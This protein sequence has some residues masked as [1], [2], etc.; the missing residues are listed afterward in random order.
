MQRGGAPCQAARSS[1]YGCRTAHGLPVRNR[2][3]SIYQKAG[4]AWITSLVFRCE[5]QSGA[6]SC[7]GLKML[8]HDL[9]ELP[10]NRPVRLRNEACAYC[11]VA[12]SKA[13]RTKDHVIG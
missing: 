5:F 6:D 9:T 2:L 11:G 8:T 10:A 4:H 1:V 13:N 12:L 7:Y 3:Q